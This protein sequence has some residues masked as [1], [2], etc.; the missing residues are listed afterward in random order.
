[1]RIYFYILLDYKG[2]EVITSKERF[3]TARHAAWVANKKVSDIPP[4]CGMK[5]RY[6]TVN[7]SRVA[8]LLTQLNHASTEV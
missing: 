2:Q 8:S 7:A 1:M 6:M 3:A 4:C 5:I